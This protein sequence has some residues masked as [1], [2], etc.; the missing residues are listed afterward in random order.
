MT[1]L[2]RDN[3]NIFIYFFNAWK[4]AQSTVF[5]DYVQAYSRLGREY[6]FGGRL[7]P[8]RRKNLESVYQIRN[9]SYYIKLDKILV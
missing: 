2:S 7:C 1:K 9:L 3:I 6:N 4:P 8:E 5:F